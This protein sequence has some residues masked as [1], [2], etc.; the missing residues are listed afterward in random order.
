MWVRKV[1]RQVFNWS[2]AIVYDDCSRGTSGALPEQAE[3][4][5]VQVLSTPLYFGRNGTVTC[6]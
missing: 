6:A 4:A 5:D 2:I 3:G 1:F